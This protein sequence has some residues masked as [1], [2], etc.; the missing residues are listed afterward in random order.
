[1]K[2]VPFEFVL[3]VL[4]RANPRIR[5]MFGCQAIYLGEKIVLILR[6]RKDYQEDNGVW[7]ATTPEHHVSLRKDF[8]SLR[9]IRLLEARGSTS[10]QNLPLEADDFEETVIKA[11]EFIL[12]GDV[13]I[14]KIPKTRSR[15][16]A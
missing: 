12:K 14:G 1:M 3:E 9:S 15:K 16:K 2:K 7:I 10:W 8:P 5:P 11:C 6:M 4:G 13:R